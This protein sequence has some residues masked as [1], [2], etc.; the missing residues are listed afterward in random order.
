METKTFI[1]NLN[2]NHKTWKDSLG[3]NYT[4]DGVMYHEGE[5]EEQTIQKWLASPKRIAILLK[6]QHQF[7]NGET[8]DEDIRYWLKSTEWGEKWNTIA[9]NNR[10]L[11]NRFLKNIAYIIWGLMKADKDNDWQYNDVA[12]HHEEVKELFNT[13]PFAFVECKKYPGGPICNNAILIQHL[14]SYGN[15]LKKELEILNPNMIICTSGIIY[16][17][18]LRNYP[19]DE[20]TVIPGHNSIRYHQKTDTLI[21]ASYHPSARKSNATIYDGVMEHYRAFLKSK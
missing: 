10:N 8:W 6:D 2:A 18:V 12:A 14:N 21:F 11:G 13:L 4:T 16:D 17:F 19:A 7:G 3:T 15:L 1:E 9:A 20:L 5:S